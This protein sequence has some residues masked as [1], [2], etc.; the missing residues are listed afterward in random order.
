M[1][2]KII[3]TIEMWE[4][5]EKKYGADFCRNVADRHHN[6]IDY[7]LEV[8]RNCRNSKIL[9]WS[10]WLENFN[11]LGACLGVAFIVWILGSFSL[12]RHEIFDYSNP[13]PSGRYLHFTCICAA[14]GVTLWIVGLWINWLSCKINYKTDGVHAAISNIKEWAELFGR[15]PE[16]SVAFR[17]SVDKLVLKVL[18]L[19]TTF[20]PD[21]AQKYGESVIKSDIRTRMSFAHKMGEIG[22]T[23]VTP[24][25]DRMKIELEK[26]RSR[27]EVP[28]D[29]VI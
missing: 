15:S 19:Q 22:A 27:G 13:L 14:L 20:G 24:F 4:A 2:R 12:F 3:E 23:D 29:Y 6:T 17:I 16:L 28:M 8:L 11:K 10:W 18:L 7:D 9:S 21:E 5:A 25:Y 1:K 26:L